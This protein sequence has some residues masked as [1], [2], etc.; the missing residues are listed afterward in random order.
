MGERSIDNS[1]FLRNRKTGKTYRT[2][3]NW[4]TFTPVL[5]QDLR[6]T[7]PDVNFVGIRILPPRDLS[8]FL[9][10]NCEDYNSPEVE[11]H[12]LNWKK[13][14][15][16]QLKDVDTMFTL[17]YHLLPLQMILNLRSMRVQP[18]HKSRKHL[19]SH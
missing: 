19:L 12:R 7:Y 8:S 18:K 10:I 15:Q 5:L 17:D 9:R 3:D 4:S 1:C 2:G 11:K 14:N 6:D 13:Q 16:Y